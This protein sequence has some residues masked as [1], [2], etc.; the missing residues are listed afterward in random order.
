MLPNKR[1]RKVQRQEGTDGQMLKTDLKTGRTL[2]EVSLW[3]ILTHPGF[4][5]I[6]TQAF[7]AHVCQNT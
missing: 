5:S 7:T 4:L 3:D 6:K 1:A 2:T